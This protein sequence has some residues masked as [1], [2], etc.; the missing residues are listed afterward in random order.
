MLWRFYRFFNLARGARDLSFNLRLTWRLLGDTR[1]PL[2]SKLIVPATLLYM[3]WPLDILPDLLPFLG[4]VDDVTAI[5]LAISFFQRVSPAALVAEHR[6][7][8]LGRRTASRAERE[9]VVIEGRYQVVD[10]E[11]R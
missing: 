6:A 1:V 9:G 2:A 4:Q 5:F 11:R 3:L 7:D 8:L 10:E